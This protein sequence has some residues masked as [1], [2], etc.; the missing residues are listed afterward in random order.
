MKNRIFLATTVLAL[1]GM[2][3][4][5]VLAQQTG[6]VTGRVLRTLVTTDEMFGGCMALL[7]SNPAAVMP[8]CG[9]RWISLGCVDAQGQDSVRGYRMLDQAQMALALNKS[10]LVRFSDSTYDGYCVATRVD[11]Y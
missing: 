4:M 8:G 7:S 10:V 11:V 6:V 5:P 1:T 3:A 2:L 9:A